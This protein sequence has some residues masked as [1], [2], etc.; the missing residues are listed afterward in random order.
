M[1]DD[2][3]RGWLLCRGEPLLLGGLLRLT[4]CCARLPKSMQHRKQNFAGSAAPASG[5]PLML[6]EEVNPFIPST[7]CSTC[8]M[9][10]HCFEHLFFLQYSWM[11][12]SVSW[13]RSSCSWMLSCSASQRSTVPSVATCSKGTQQLQRWR[14]L[15]PHGAKGHISTP[16]KFCAVHGT[17]L[18]NILRPT[19]EQSVWQD[20][21][22]KIWN[23]T[24]ISSA[25]GH[26]V[27]EYT[28]C[29]S[30]TTDHKIINILF[31]TIMLFI[32]IQ[33]HAQ[34]QVLV[35]NAESGDCQ[36][37]TTVSQMHDH[38]CER[39]R[40]TQLVQ[41]LKQQDS[42]RIALCAAMK[43][44]SRRDNV[45]IFHVEQN[46]DSFVPEV[47]YQTCQLPHSSPAARGGREVASMLP[48]LLCLS[49]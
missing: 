9:P 43:S 18:S 11:P 12:H 38:L 25:T 8:E 48:L 15:V 34:L 36:H 35:E 37:Y 27:E 3:R 22:S 29:H 24:W 13:K 32:D 46:C 1:H 33:H 19:W 41:V 47:S 14:H 39:R 49:P 31:I 16:S 5:A 7:T 28:F 23:W 44:P 26:A 45:W 20:S 30:P 10:H 4:K 2:Q 21:T 40:D 42:I 17:V 6:A